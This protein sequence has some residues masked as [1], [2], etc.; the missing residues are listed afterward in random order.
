[1][2]W[3]YVYE[4]AT[5]R[6]VSETSLP[7]GD[8]DARYAVLEL[9]A[10]ARDDQMWDLASRGFVPRPAK[11]LMDRIADLEV[12]GSLA[13]VWTRLTVQQRTALKNRLAAVLGTQRFRHPNE[14]VE[15]G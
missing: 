12:D 8:L 9:P 13:A 3:S 14:P 11:V 6:L 7:L 5:G 10:R 1:M 2:A 4:A 15:I